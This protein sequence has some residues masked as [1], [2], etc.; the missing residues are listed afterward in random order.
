M[1]KMIGIKYTLNRLSPSNDLDDYIFNING[2][3]CYLDATKPDGKNEQKIGKITAYLVNV[4]DCLNEDT[5]IEHVMDNHSNNVY[6]YYDLLIDRSKN[7]FKKDLIEDQEIPSN[8]NLLII[9]RIAIIPKYR[10]INI[11]LAVIS[12]L[13]RVFGHGC[14]YVVTKAF[15]LQFEVGTR[16]DDYERLGPNELARDKELAT[17]KLKGHYSKLGFRNIKGTD[18]MLLNLDYCDRP[19]I[20]FKDDKFVLC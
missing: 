13:I 12:D 16:S 18:F 2:D 8:F 20:D 3:I 7:D 6:Q 10:K 15:P 1:E 4:T 19:I 14:G 5:S 9:D 17:L 11:S